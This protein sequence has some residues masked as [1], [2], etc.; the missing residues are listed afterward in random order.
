MW[1]DCK[2]LMMLDIPA[3]FLVKFVLEFRLFPLWSS[4]VTSGS[5]NHLLASAV[6]M[7]LENVNVGAEK[8]ETMKGGIHMNTCCQ[9]KR[10]NCTICNHIQG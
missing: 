10:K 7:P 3:E 8:A 1:A 5:G 2:V 4:Q 9:M 6:R